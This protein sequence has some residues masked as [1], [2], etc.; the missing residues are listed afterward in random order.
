M[1]EDLCNK[2]GYVDYTA[3]KAIKSADGA[4]AKA[5]YCY[6]ALVSVARLAGF[7]ILGT[8][9]LEDRTGRVHKSDVV[10]RRR[11]DELSGQTA[12]SEGHSD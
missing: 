7:N 6:K 8:V 4:V 10:V 2:E 9:F 5:Y 11:E 1:N 12:E 3:Y